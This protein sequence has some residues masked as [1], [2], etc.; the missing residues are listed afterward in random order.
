MSLRVFRHVH[1]ELSH[2]T[3]DGAVDPPAADA[4]RYDAML[5]AV[6]IAR[7]LA[8]EK[9]RALYEA[10]VEAEQPPGCDCSVCVTVR[11]LR[12]VEQDRLAVGAYRDRDGFWVFPNGLPDGDKWSGLYQRAEG[13]W[14]YPPGDGEQAPPCPA[15]APDEA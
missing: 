9:G 14:V 2:R 6:A 4:V 10:W 12:Q 8:P 5:E 13:V 11:E 3:R 1:H 15:P 7:G